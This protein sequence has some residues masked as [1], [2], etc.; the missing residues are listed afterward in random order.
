MGGGIDHLHSLDLKSERDVLVL[1]QPE[2]LRYYPN[3]RV[4]SLLLIE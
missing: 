2:L 1:W 4:R 3:T